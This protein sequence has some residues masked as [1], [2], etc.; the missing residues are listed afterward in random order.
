[1]IKGFR[2]K[3]TRTLFETGKCKRFANVN[4]VAILRIP[5]KLGFKS[6]K[7]LQAI[8]LTHIYPA[9]FGKV[10]AI[11]LVSRGLTTAQ[12]F[13]KMKSCRKS[14]TQKIAR[15]SRDSTKAGKNDKSAPTKKY[16]PIAVVRVR[17][18]TLRGCVSFAGVRCTLV[19]CRVVA[20]KGNHCRRPVGEA[21]GCTRIHKPQ[22]CVVGFTA[23]P[24]TPA[25]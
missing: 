2:C 22:L 23:S 9:D 14:I 24:A 25:S 4:R 1:M 17:A 15:C 20:T 7:Y 18:E 19:F 6:A 11:R 5:T 21:S 8:E 12:G 13:K 16:L 10:K 3:D